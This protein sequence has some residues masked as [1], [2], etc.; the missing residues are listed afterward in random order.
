LDLLAQVARAHVRF[1]R[2]RLLLRLPPLTPEA[3][4]NWQRDFDCYL[5][6]ADGVGDAQ[7]ADSVVRLKIQPGQPL[8]RN[9]AHRLARPRA[10][11][12]YANA[13]FC[14]AVSM[15]AV[16]SALAAFTCPRA[17][18]TRLTLERSK[19]VCVTRARPS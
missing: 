9:R 1:M 7:P 16:R 12:V 19:S 14:A 15:T 13:T 8:G 18:L 3:V 17:A 5:S 2:H 10:A 6:C 11:R 4:E